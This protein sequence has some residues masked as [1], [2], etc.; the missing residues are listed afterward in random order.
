MSD[1]LQ[2]LSSII[3]RKLYILDDE[4]N[5]RSSKVHNVLPFSVIDDIFEDETM[6]KTLRDLLNDL[7]YEILTGGIGNI[8]FPVTSVNGKTGDVVITAAD[9]N[10][11]RVDNTADLDKPLS[12]PQREA[13]MNILTNY[14]FHVN[15]QELYDHIMDTNNPHK[16]T[17]EQLDANGSLEE[18][19]K[20]LI[21][22][23]NQ[24]REHTTHLDIR[25]SLATL[26]ELVETIKNSI[27]EK[28]N[29]TLDTAKVHYTDQFAHYDLFSKKENLINKVNNFNKSTNNDSDKYPTTRAVSEYVTNE[30]K[31]FK[32]TLPNVENWIDDIK[33]INSADQLPNPTIKYAR[34]AYFIAQ[35]VTSH[36]DVA[37]CRINPD[38]STYSWDIMNLGSFSKF[39]EKYFIDT[40]DGMSLNLNEIAEALLADDGAFNNIIKNIFDNYYTKDEIDKSHYVTD[41][42]IITGDEL[43]C[44]KYYINND[45]S[46]MS[47]NIKVHGLQRLAYLEWITEKELWDNS[48]HSRH[49]KDYSIE[50]RHLQDQSVTMEK[51][52][53]PYGYMV[54]NTTNETLSEAHP[55]TL[56]QLADALRPLIGGW[57]DPA[58]PGGNPYYDAIYDIIPH[59][60]TF[61]PG[62]E[63]DM[64][65]HSYMRR[66]KGVVSSIRNQDAS[67][68]LT[69]DLTSIDYNVIDSGGSWVYQSNPKEITTLG[70]SNI[71]G[72]TFGSIILT[73][74]GLFLHTI[75]IG[76]RRDAPFDVWVRYTKNA[77][78]GTYN[79][80]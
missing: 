9:L 73:E 25:R 21:A 22:L 72:F 36:P 67:N 56:I 79:D 40:I 53:V 5:P 78:D 37:I 27:D 48:V 64:G 45:I 39:H 49:I 19:V 51:I 10:L 14:D 13:I 70:G 46:T 75:S 55:V 3:H 63:Y 26:W 15:L 58:V 76:D 57:P 28:V 29:D 32:D 43:G 77:E 50:T 6:S 74:E 42:N 12:T 1:R 80:K 17:I 16:V 20:K 23:H 47:E 7:H 52:K 30:I 35:G 33:V 59:P 66:Y 18:F 8:E 62:I 54:G 11:G 68:L 24:S 4:E 38:G 60:H 65:D 2:R 34:K 31:N 44:I 61:S 41:L 71:T 69:T